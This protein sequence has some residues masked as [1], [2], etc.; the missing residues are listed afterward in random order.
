[1]TGA[2]VLTIGKAVIW[3][4][5]PLAFAIWQLISVR[6]ETNRDRERSG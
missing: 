5:F 3:W 6:R 2:E 1:M 4:V